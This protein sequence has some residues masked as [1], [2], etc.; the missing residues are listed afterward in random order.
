M[1][2]KPKIRIKL[3]AYDHRLLDQSAAEIV[4]TAKRTGAKIAG[5][6]PLPTKREL[7]TV[8]RSPV[9]DKKSREQFQLTTHKRLIDIVEPTSKTVDALRKLNLPSGVYVEVK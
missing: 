3:K 6:V 8:L 9:I 7:Y 1:A 2:E 4:E 5:P